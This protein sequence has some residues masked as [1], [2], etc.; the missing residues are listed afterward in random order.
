MYNGSGKFN[1]TVAFVAAGLSLIL[2]SFAS[3]P[4]RREESRPAAHSA[5]TPYF[6]TPA[7]DDGGPVRNAGTVALQTSKYLPPQFSLSGTTGWPQAR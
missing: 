7:G 2:M 5:R 6:C 3:R 1:V 4:G